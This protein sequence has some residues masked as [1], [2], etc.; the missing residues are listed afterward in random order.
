MRVLLSLLKILTIN[1]FV[2][3]LALTPIEIFLRIKMPIEMF[4]M[5]ASSELAS[6]VGWGPTM[7]RESQNN[8]NVR[9]CDFNHKSGVSDDVK[10][11]MTI[12]DSM[13]DCNDRGA[14]FENTIPYLLQQSLGKR[15]KVFNL[16][17][18]GWGTDQELLAFIH[19]RDNIDPDIVILFYTP[20]NDLFNNISR[21][22]INENIAKPVFELD[23]ENL[24]KK[25]V[26][27]LHKSN[28]LSK[29]LF[30]TEIYKR[31]N[32][33]M[34]EIIEF[35]KFDVRED[36]PLTTLESENY[37]HM[38]GFLSPMLPRY[39]QSWII[40]KKIL[41][42]FNSEVEAIGADFLLVYLP[43]GARN[44]CET[45]EMFPNNCIGY[46]E[47]RLIPV[48][49]GAGETK[50]DMYQQYDLIFDLAL[51]EGF[52][53]IEAFDFFKKYESNHHELAADCIHFHNRIGPEAIVR[54]I[55]NEIN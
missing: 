16:A 10:V 53:V 26:H 54:R 36:E 55:L 12:G 44:H 41:S 14:K 38:S 49:C 17:A 33:S 18:G 30:K 43:T 6:A 23:G 2:L 50:F 19:E 48:N 45:I 46:G 4:F 21:K 9:A 13:L 52:K 40:T 42:E 24:I 37:A 35:F 7:K 34:P 5:D 8:S 3:A 39:K 1:F 15:F 29:I 51:S 32:L 22:A 25:E 20:A 31:L 27:Y 47:R 11:I 28:Y